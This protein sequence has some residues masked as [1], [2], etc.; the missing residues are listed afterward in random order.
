MSMKRISLV[1]ALA[2]AVSGA[3][4]V[5]PVAFARSSQNV[6]ITLLTKQHG[7]NLSGSWHAQGLG[8]G[9]VKGTLVIP[10]TKLTLT[11]GGYGSFSTTTFHCSNEHFTPP[12]FTGCWK[13]VHATGKF[14]GMTGGGKFAGNISGHTTYNGTVKY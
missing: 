12:T 3:A 6:S 4:V 11:R 14:K 7:T 10:L 1:V 13:V 8:S 9:S 5:A 2:T